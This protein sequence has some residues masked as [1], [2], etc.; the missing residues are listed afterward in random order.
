MNVAGTQ[1]V[2]TAEPIIRRFI[3]PA[4]L[5]RSYALENELGLSSSRRVWLKDYGFTPTGSFKVM[6]ALNW[7]ANNNT[8][9]GDRPVAARS[10]GNFAAGLSFAC[11]QF[12]KR[13]IIVMPDTAPQMKFDLT[14]SFGAEIQT[15]D[16][17][18]DHQ[19]G[20][21]AALLEKI[22][23]QENA[24][25]ASPYDDNYVIAGN[26]VGGL[27][28]ANFLKE[29]DRRLSHFVC[30]VSGG[31]LMAGHLLS[32]AAAF[33]SANMIA[34]EPAGADDFR[35]SLKA[36]KRLSIEHPQSVC[37]GLLSY[38]VGEHNWPILS[39]HV[40]DAL[41]VPDS[42]TIEAMKWVYDCHGLRTEPS[43][44]ITIAAML[45]GRLDV[46]DEG[47][48]VAVISGRNIDQSQFEKYLA[49]Y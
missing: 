45:S 47:D 15:Y 40:T 20:A 32:I 11:Q 7:V 43:G 6:G 37:D 4:P 27:E 33:P 2:L 1:D 3:T 28:I 22:V 18:N 49:E 34:V 13:A 48:I 30:A 25:M 17:A 26:G 38:D 44:V 41:A 19:T 21:R 9:I 24:V 31:G 42:S 12:G 39:E 36:N 5:I 29:N 14:R 10:S 8:K 23:A 16:I 35:Q 46:S